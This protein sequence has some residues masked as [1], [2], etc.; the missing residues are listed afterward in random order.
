[1]NVPPLEDL[2]RN[3]WY[4]GVRCVC[5]RFLAL[6]E[7]CFQGKSAEA[8]LPASIPLTVQCPCGVA[9]HAQVLHKFKVT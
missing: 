5:Q 8:V 1:M 7:D 9:N 2:K 6:C 4:Y 3:T